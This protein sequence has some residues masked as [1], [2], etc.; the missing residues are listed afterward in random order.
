MRL[1]LL[2]AAAGALTLHGRDVPLR[3]TESFRRRA[4]TLS[5]EPKLFLV[6]TGVHPPAEVV[7]GYLGRGVYLVHTPT[8]EGLGGN[9]SL[10]Q[11]HHKYDPGIN[12]TLG[13]VIKC[14]NS[15]RTFH[16]GRPRPLSRTRAF[17]KGPVHA[18]ALQLIAQSHNVIWIAPVRKAARHA[19]SQRRELVFET[20]LGAPFGAGG[21][22]LIS[23]TGLDTSHCAFDDSQ[24]VPFAALPQAP[25]WPVFNGT[26]KV[27]GV[28][29][30]EY[31]PGRYTTGQPF[32]D[33]HG[34]AT[35]GTAAG[36]YCG[37][38]GGTA[39]ASRFL[40]L[41]MTVSPGEIS[42]PTD[43]EAVFAVM[44][45]NSLI[46]HTASWGYEDAFG[47]YD[48]Q[49]INFDE[50]AWQYQK[51][52]VVSAGNAGPNLVASPATCKNCLSV[53]AGFSAA[54]D[55]GAYSAVQRAAY[56]AWYSAAS[57]ASFS[58]VG[59]LP[60]GRRA[61]VL[62][63]QGVYVYVPLA[64]ATPS[65]F[66]DDYVYEDGT[67]F[68]GPGIAGLNLDF[69]DAHFRATGLNASA[70]L[71]MA[72]MI[73][74]AAPTSV[75]VDVG[76]TTLTLNPAAPR[77][78]SYGVPRLNYSA[79]VYLDG[80][81]TSGERAA[82]CFQAAGGAATAALAWIDPPGFYGA[83]LAIVN[84]LDLYLYADGQEYTL[85]DFVNTNEKV[86]ANASGA[87]R[88]VVAVDG[89]VAALVQNFSLAL[90]GVGA[91]ET[92]GTC[93]FDDT[94]GCAAGY[95]QLC[96]P[97]SGNSS[98]ALE[99]CPSG[100]VYNGTACVA[101]I[102]NVPCAVPYGSGIM[103]NGTCYAQQCDAFY[104]LQGESCV[105]RP[106][107]P[108]AAGQ[109]PAPCVN[110]AFAACASAPARP[111]VQSTPTIGPQ[112]LQGTLWVWFVTIPVLLVL[113]CLCVACVNFDRRDRNP[114][115]APVSGLRKVK[116]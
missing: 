91:F 3:P 16:Y 30:F 48:D 55:Y 21:R 116:L 24:E 105:C 45:A 39:N 109:N 26:G 100:T 56:P 89:A 93:L 38:G 94:G 84:D 22:F 92:C 64:F 115:V 85:G 112:P 2:A 114:G 78:L 36:Y 76:A 5:A 49:A 82:F 8:P 98:C 81:Q 77:D 83:A 52:H 107:R 53:G 79:G 46:L 31:A 12:T 102:S 7:R 72:A 106:Q 67:S 61:P 58:S 69:H 14:V 57:V 15:S 70:A 42:A 111:R 60:D 101:A 18:N 86:S 103:E 33:A 11:A 25:P 96:D 108:C 35:A 17:L 66:H 63:A 68:A 50:V 37:G 9:F 44:A 23:D 51:H 47:L 6:Q 4:S 87:V 88:V 62:V 32:D 59:P 40:F 80:L 20:P 13:V 28:A 95:T 34:T 73:L 27:L 74:F 90:S 110:N 19:L 104:L 1:L 54:S 113:C 75:V 10:Y 43:F 99:D 97:A 29:T 65:A 41:D 71:I